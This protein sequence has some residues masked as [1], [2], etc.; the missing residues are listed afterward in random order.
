MRQI[1]RTF[2]VTWR[3][4]AGLL[5]R[6]PLLA[7]SLQHSL[8][9][10]M[11]VLLLLSQIHLLLIANFSIS[12]LDLYSSYFAR[13]PATGGVFFAWHPCIWLTRSIA[14]RR[15][16]PIPLVVGD[17]APT[18]P[19]CHRRSAQRRRRTRWPMF[20]NPSTAVRRCRPTPLDLGDLTPNYAIERVGGDSMVVEPAP[21]ATHESPPNPQRHVRRGD[22]PDG[23]HT[24]HPRTPA[25][26]TDK[27]T[28]RSRILV[29]AAVLDGV[30]AGDGTMAFATQTG[31]G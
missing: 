2:T 22:T 31:I 30:I 15:C 16:R 13:D 4:T 3:K 14:T 6:T 23:R 27:P 8:A 10:T 9:T 1:L 24:K 21:T 20:P 11:Y 28:D 25:T 7:Q 18:Y 19:S 29:P 5:R 26:A 12:K 17:V